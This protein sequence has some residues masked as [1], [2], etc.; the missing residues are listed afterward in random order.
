[1]QGCFLRRPAQGSDTHHRGLY[2]M[3]LGTA[4]VDDSNASDAGCGRDTRVTAMP[5]MYGGLLDR[6]LM[7]KDSLYALSE[8]LRTIAAAENQALNLIQSLVNAERDPPPAS[9]R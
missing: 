8:L 4:A 7:A 6:K 2:V 3:V 1:M 5:Q 9:G